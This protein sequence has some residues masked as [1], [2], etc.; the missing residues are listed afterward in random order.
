MS[1]ETTKAQNGARPF[2]ERVL[3]MLTEMRADLGARLEKLEARAYDTKPIWERA[4]ADIAELR[5][6]VQ[7]G[8]RNTDRQIGVLSK[9]IV[10]LRADVGD[11]VDRLHDLERKG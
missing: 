8:F 3:T 1:E 9:D 5:Q 10:Q 6:V 7:A 11:A 2:E 4:L